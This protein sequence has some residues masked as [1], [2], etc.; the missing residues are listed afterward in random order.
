[1][2][3]EDGM[4]GIKEK[5]KLFPKE[6]RFSHHLGRFIVIAKAFI[7]YYGHVGNQQHY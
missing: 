2:V 3:L 5:A 1:M 4:D 6:E 7:S